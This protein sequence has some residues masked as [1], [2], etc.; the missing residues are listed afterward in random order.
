M[1][2]P[3]APSTCRLL[4]YC[5]TFCRAICR[6]L[7]LHHVGYHTRLPLLVYH[8]FTFIATVTVLLLHWFSRYHF[9]VVPFWITFCVLPRLHTHA[10]AVRLVVTAFYTYVT[11]AFCGLRFGCC[12]LH[13]CLRSRVVTT[14]VRY[15]YLRSASYVTT[16]LYSS[17]IR[18]VP[19]ALHLPGCTVTLLHRTQFPAVVAGFAVTLPFDYGYTRLIAVYT[20]YH[21]FYVCALRFT[22]VITRLVRLRWILP[23]VRTFCVPAV[24]RFLLRLLTHAYIRTRLRFA[25]VLCH[26]CSLPRSGSRGSLV[27]RG[28][29]F[30]WVT[31]PLQVTVYGYYATYVCRFRFAVP[32]DFTHYRNTWF[33][34][35]LLVLTQF[36]A[37]H[38]FPPLHH[39]GYL[40]QF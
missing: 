18:F 40:L 14:H 25:L 6:S 16:V 8:A 39:A 28:Y 15:V 2:L 12:R 37:F 17:V 11:H 36:A 9:T 7:R 24:T 3:F 32:F 20:P 22:T 23:F 1:F 38:T 13:V 4:P 30:A 26:V 10:T 29:W 34:T 27:H 35:G 21:T 19:H 31:T 33:R 5:V